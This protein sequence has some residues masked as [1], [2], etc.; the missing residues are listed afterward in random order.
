MMH[1]SG[2]PAGVFD[3]MHFSCIKQWLRQSVAAVQ[4]RR[5]ASDMQASCINAELS[6]PASEMC[7]TEGGALRRSPPRRRHLGASLTP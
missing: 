2:R 7:I 6:A 5:S 1:I 4:T 3:V